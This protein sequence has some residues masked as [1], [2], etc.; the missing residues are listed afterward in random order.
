MG[1]M[2]FHFVTVTWAGE[3]ML[4]RQHVALHSWTTKWPFAKG[5]LV[6]KV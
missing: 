2:T 4:I 3:S 6:T 5:G 1:D